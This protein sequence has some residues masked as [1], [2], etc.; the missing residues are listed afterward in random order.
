MANTVWGI[1][2]QNDNLFL[3]NNV[4]AIGWK[5]FGKLDKEQ[6]LTQASEEEVRRSLTD[7]IR[8]GLLETSGK[9]YMMTA[10]V[11]E[12]VKSDVE[13]TRD[14]KIQYIRAKE[15]ITEYIKMHGSITKAIVQELCGFSDQQARRALE[16]M[17]KE[18]LLKLVSTG[19][20]AKYVLS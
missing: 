17:Q 19:R 11:Y 9:D 5:A 14:K 8:Y 3:K 6:E 10:C 20:Y 2:T 1:H 16:K 12:A 13:Y 15:M 4:I 18:N 7:L